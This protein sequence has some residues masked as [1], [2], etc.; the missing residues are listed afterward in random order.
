MIDQA[1][2]ALFQARAQRIP[3][4]PISVTYG[5]ADARQ[6]YAVQ[7]RNTRRYLEAGR[8][9]SGRKIGLTAKAVQQ[10]MGVGEPDYGMLWQDT[11]FDHGAVVPRGTFMQPRIE[12]E[13]GFVLSRPL[14]EDN[15]TLAD[16]MS[17]IEYAVPAIEI[18]DSAVADWKISLSDTIADNASA[19]GYVIG[20][21]PRPL[22]ALDLRLCGMILSQRGRSLSLGTGAACL[23]HPLNAVRWLART[24]FAVGRP[25]DAGDLVL[26]GAL[27]PMVPVDGTDLYAVEIQGFSPVTIAFD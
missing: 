22:G 13:I 20:A 14:D 8:V 16:V 3:I 27:G 18:V 4:P 7:E 10:Q 23:D 11:C 2:Q 6:A 5:I 24:M 12:A 17:A 9:I 1:A 15:P 26:S 21:N 19:G 25:L